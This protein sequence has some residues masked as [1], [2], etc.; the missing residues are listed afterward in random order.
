V[1]GRKA[2]SD[3]VETL[4]WKIEEWDK[5]RVSHW[6]MQVVYINSFLPTAWPLYVPDFIP[7]YSLGTAMVVS[8]EWHCHKREQRQPK[9]DD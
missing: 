7:F 2:T 5:K 3:R 1:I 8:F 6:I 4:T 9:Q